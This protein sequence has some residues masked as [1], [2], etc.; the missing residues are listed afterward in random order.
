MAELE[1]ITGVPVRDVWRDEARDFT[2]WLGANADLL[3]EALGLD[4]ELVETEVPVG[5]F[6]ADAHFRV[7]STGA[8]VVVENML[9]PSDHDH[10]GKLLTYASGIDASHAVLI[11]ERLKPEHASALSWLNKNSRDGISF[12]GIEIAVWRIGDSAPAPHLD[13]VVKPDQWQRAVQPRTTPRTA[14]QETYYD[15]WDFLLPKLREAIPGWTN[16][17]APATTNWYSFPAGRS[18]LSY[19]VVFASPGGSAD[20][21]LRIEL[22]MKLTDPAATAAMYEHLLAHRTQIEATFGAPLEW[23]ANE[24]LMSSKVLTNYGLGTDPNDRDRWGEYAEWTLDTLGRFRAAL[25]PHVL[26]FSNSDA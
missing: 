4:L 3:G 11:A 7:S 2:P 6:S 26:A 20:Y 25:H 23:Q 9:T 12:F 16:S 10:L 22:Y 19:S 15:W 24:H 1:R 17:R 14:L 18:G 13:V 21:V 8:D 5:S